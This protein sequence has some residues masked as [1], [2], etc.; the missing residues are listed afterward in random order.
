M[1]RNDWLISALCITFLFG[2][3]LRQKAETT[4]PSAKTPK[5][6]KPIHVP[7]AATPAARSVMSAD[8][9]TKGEIVG[10]PLPDSK[11]GRLEIGMTL[12]QVENLI[13]R[14][15]KTD[16]RIT[17]KQYQPL[18]YGGDTLRTEAF[19]KDEGQLTFSNINPDSAADTLIRIMVYPNTTGTR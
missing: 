11:F 2:C 8:G 1:Y 6:A 5:A 13:G 16:S 7:S 17:G 4:K 15:D 18:Y 10:I 12:K 3:A 9:L 14:P 19:Y